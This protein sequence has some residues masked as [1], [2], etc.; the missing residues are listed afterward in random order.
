MN[1]T[2]SSLTPVLVF[3]P[4]SSSQGFNIG[5]EA[6]YF[7]TR[8]NEIGGG[9]FLSVDRFRFCQQSF[10]DGVVSDKICRSDTRVGLG[11]T[12]L[13]RY[14]FAKAEAKGFP[15]IGGTVSVSDVTRNFTGNV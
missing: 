3:F 1:F 8:K 2:I 4:S 7:L 15:F 14:N 5:G 10:M 9:L 11:L 13:Y 12:G 6:G